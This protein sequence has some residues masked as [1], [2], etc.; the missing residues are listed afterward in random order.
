[1][2]V[3]RIRDENGEFQ[4]IP[5]IKGEPGKDGARQYTAGKNIEITKD[6]VIN[7]TVEGGGTVI[8]DPVPTQGSKHAVSSG[9]TFDAL[10]QKADKGDIPTD[11]G[12]LENSAGYISNESDPVFKA[13]A[14]Y[15]ISHQN[16]LNW[17]N[18]A[19]LSD[20]VHQISKL[21][22]LETMTDND[23]IPSLFRLSYEKTNERL[24][25]L[26]LDLMFSL[27][28]ISIKGLVNT[29]FLY[30]TLKDASADNVLYRNIGA[31]LMEY[32][33]K[34]MFMGYDHVNNEY[35]SPISLA[36]LI[37][38]LSMLGPEIPV[39]FTD[40]T[41]KLELSLLAV[42]SNE[43]RDYTEVVIKLVPNDALNDVQFNP[44]FV[45]IYIPLSR[46]ITFLTNDKD[47]NWLHAI[48]HY[49]S[50]VDRYLW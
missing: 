19:E 3:L 37:G 14:A 8:I 24:P 30:N 21:D 11:V 36:N 16:I 12:D 42:H 50:S 9:G 17:E 38:A 10:A 6:D 26:E 29:G 15:G 23:S 2:A 32:D 20:I 43:E 34:V 13:S 47:P 31:N 45:F 27:T 18:K 1:M 46:L 35:G 48:V 7:C 39:Y 41:N 22:L 49:S 4:S 5:A 44:G 25:D 33:S 40:G 28:G